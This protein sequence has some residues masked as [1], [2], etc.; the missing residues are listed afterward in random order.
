MNNDEV[1]I[2]LD[3]YHGSRE[4]PMLKQITNDAL[5]QLVEINE[6]LKP[7]VEDHSP[8]KTSAKAVPAATVA[9]KV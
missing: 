3:I 2:L 9:R 6:G 1:K 8:P 5:A 7:E 4:L